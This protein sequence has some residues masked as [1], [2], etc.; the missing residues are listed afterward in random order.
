M[1]WQLSDT[2]QVCRR[3]GHAQ[4]MTEFS[5]VRQGAKNRHG[6]VHREC[7][8]C[9]QG[10]K[11]SV[12]RSA[13]I[14]T[15]ET[16][17]IDAADLEGP[18]DGSAGFLDLYLT[19]AL[20][21]PIEPPPPL[22][23]ES[24]GCEFSELS[25][26]LTDRFKA[27]ARDDVPVYA[28]FVVDCNEEHWDV[29]RS[30]STMH[31]DSENDP[32]AGPDSFKAWVNDSLRP[33]LEVGTGFY[34]EVR[35]YSRTVNVTVDTA[36]GT[37]YVVAFYVDDHP[38]PSWRDNVFPAK[39]KDFLAKFSAA[40]ARKH[41]LY[42][43]LHQQGY[44]DASKVTRAQ[45]NYWVAEIESWHYGDNEEDQLKSVYNFLTRENMR[46]K[47]FEVTL[48]EDTDEVRAIAFNTLFWKHAAAVKEV[49]M[50][51]TFKTN[52]LRFEMFVVVANLGG[53]GVPLNYMFYLKK[54]GIGDPSPSLYQM[55][56]TRKLLLGRWLGGLHER[57]LQP[58]F[59]L[60]DVVPCLIFF[61]ALRRTLVK[62]EV[63][64]TARGQNLSSISC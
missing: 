57:G 46:S 32:S 4:E 37:C 25:R 5:R 19:L 3:C 33:E 28:R 63:E 31:P 41:D 17:T 62:I 1:T 45:V 55:K 16:G 58:V 42:R 56:R 12:S 60:S 18:V 64:S 35:K 11:R 22:N 13:Q 15:L 50:D 43:M 24:A 7:N 38:K 52:A 61:V 2:T 8:R 34:W 27:S 9:Y 21:V 51:S 59:V 10:R 29:C 53:F 40:E 48:F 44:I 30:W 26:A 20:P 36:S 6:Q 39:A 14:R 49:V 47:G 54:V 23:I